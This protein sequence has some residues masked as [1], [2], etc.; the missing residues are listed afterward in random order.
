MEI[1]F[2]VNDIEKFS[3]DARINGFLSHTIRQGF[4]ALKTAFDQANDLDTAR[5]NSLVYTSLLATVAAARNTRTTG[6]DQGRI[7]EF[8]C[9][10]GLWLFTKEGPIV[11]WTKVQK[12]MEIHTWKNEIIYKK[13]AK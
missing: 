10:A 3:W 9:T 12:V 8:W 11:L 7:K 13:S 6:D 4:L 1:P 2:L 5:R